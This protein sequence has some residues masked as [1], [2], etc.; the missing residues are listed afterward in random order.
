VCTCPIKRP[1]AKKPGRDFDDIRNA[2]AVKK[3]IGVHDDLVW[4]T[5]QTL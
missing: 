1:G 3:L 5:G 4:S 2:L